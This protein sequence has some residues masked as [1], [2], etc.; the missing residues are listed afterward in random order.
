M[1][2][3]FSVYCNLAF[4]N[5]DVLDAAPATGGEVKE[6]MEPTRSESGLARRPEMSAGEV[7]GFA[8]QVTKSSYQ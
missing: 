1:G 2:L 4:S 7:G 5:A 8:G 6:R 3:V